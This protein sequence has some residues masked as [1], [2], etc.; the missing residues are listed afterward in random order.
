M[1]A[2]K[3]EMWIWWD[4]EKLFSGRETGKVDDIPLFLPMTNLLQQFSTVEELRNKF[5]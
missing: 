2:D 1:E 4:W 5:H 3:C